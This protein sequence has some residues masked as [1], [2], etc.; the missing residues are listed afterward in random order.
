MQELD[1]VKLHRETMAAAKTEL[2]EWLPLWRQLN[3][4]FYPFLYSSLLGN[5]ALTGGRLRNSKMLDGEPAVALL[6]LAGGFLNGVTSPARK[7]VN[8]KQPGSKP[9]E[10]PSPDLATWHSKT[11]DKILEVLAG[12][13]YYDTRAVQVY[14]AAGLGT[15]VLLVYEDRDTVAKFIVCP[16]GSYMLETNAEN[17]VIRFMREYKMKA[18]DILAEF[19]E[20]VLPQNILDRA[21]AGG[22]Q[23][24][25]EYLVSHIIEDNDGDNRVG[26]AHFREVYFLSSSQSGGAP[27]LARRPMYEWPVATL[28]WSCPDGAT[29]GVPPTMQ[30]LGKAIQLQNLEYKSDQGLDKMIS[31]PLLAD[32]SLQNRKKAFSAGGI[33][34][35]S[36]LSPNSGARPVYQVQVPFQEM[37]MK[38]TRIVQSIKDALFNY[39]FDM[40]SNLETVRTATEIDARREEKLVQLGPVLQR[41]YLEDIGV[42]VKRV[43]GILI[44]KQIIEPPPVNEGAEIEFRNI[45]SDVQKASDVATLERFMAF[46]GQVIPVWPDVQPKV[47]SLA[48]VTKYAEGLGVSP[49]VLYTDEE[50]QAKIDATAEMQQL[51]QVAGVAKDFGSAAASLGGVDVG[52]GM[53]AV[54]SM[55]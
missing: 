47:N 12:S 31:P 54:Q 27:Y 34:F 23:G 50:T 2:S 46:V 32:Q 41:S 28:R 24:R 20:S 33:T 45:L 19:G 6:V 4:A 26:N 18:R 13:N 15:G 53:N 48:I 21:K 43:Y 40:I 11:R 29:Y 38:R 44:R 5:T 10:E 22:A 55:L 3:E 52:G 16:P 17:R 35:T 8:V 51:A 37:D 39:L 9:Y 42:V 49:S 14:D 1:E 36:N 30:C 7:W 25:T